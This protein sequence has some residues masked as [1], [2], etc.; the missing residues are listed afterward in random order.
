MKRAEP[1]RQTGGAEQ[2][3]H[4]LTHFLGGFIGKRHSQELLREDATHTDQVGNAVRNDARFAR[5]SASQNQ[6]R[7]IAVLHCLPLG[8]VELRLESCFHPP[9]SSAVL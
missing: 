3:V 6:Q 4:T 2:L 8:S 1:E 9:A 5:S 7:P